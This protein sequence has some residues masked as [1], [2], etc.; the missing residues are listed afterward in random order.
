MNKIRVLVANRPQL[1]RD[2]VLET[3][4]DQPDIEVL[5]EIKNDSEILPRVEEWHPDFVIVALDVRE[6]PPAFCDRLLLTHPDMKILAVAPERNRSLFMW[7]ALN[8][9]TMQIETSEQGI[10][11]ALRG[12][13]HVAGI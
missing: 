4:S 3:I 6:G 1:M 13:T 7:V 11:D 2:V 9:C 8:V 12:K 10:L 5:D